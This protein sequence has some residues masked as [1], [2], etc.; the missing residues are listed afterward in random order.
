MK[1]YYVPRTRS[2]RPRWVLE[3]LGVPYELERLDPKAGDT[4]KAEY[5]AVHPLGHVPAF[6]DE[7][8]HMI[9]SAAICTYLADKY[10]EKK[11]APPAGSK[12]RGPYYQWLFFGMATLEPP[13]AA[14]ANHTRMWPEEKRVKHI[15]EDSEKRVHEVAKVIS[16]AL[17]TKEYLLGYFT[18]ADVVIGGSIIWAHLLKILPPDPRLAAYVERL[19][20]RPAWKKATAD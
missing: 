5:L 17:G 8:M 9:E 6:E 16:D 7:G 18:A 20:A 19:L 2:G 10:P 4:K 11:L 13:I 14:Y 3:E 15:A 1:L 12:E